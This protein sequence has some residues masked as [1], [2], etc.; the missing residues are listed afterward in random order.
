MGHPIAHEF[1]P[2]ERIRLTAWVRDCGY[3][4]GDRGIVLSGD[5]ANDTGWLSYYVRME[6]QPIGTWTRFTPEEIEPDCAQE[7]VALLSDAN[8]CLVADMFL[9]RGEDVDEQLDKAR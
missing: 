1:K 6:G 5:R 2:G 9:A 4:P 8:L 3:R 7:T